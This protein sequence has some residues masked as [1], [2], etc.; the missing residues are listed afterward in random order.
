[1]TPVPVA[2]SE[3]QVNEVARQAGANPISLPREKQ[4]VLAGGE[5]SPTGVTEL[6]LT[7][8]ADPSKDTPSWYTK[9]SDVDALFDVADTLDWLADSGDLNENYDYVDIDTTATTPA[10]VYTA[11]AMT[12]HGGPAPGAGVAYPSTTSMNTLPRIESGAQVVV[13]PLPS[14]F[15]GAPT[16]DSAGV[17]DMDSAEP[18]R[19]L[20]LHNL[21][22]TSVTDLDN[23]DRLQVFGTHDEE[24]E[25]VS[26][27]LDHDDTTGD[28]STSLSALGVA[29]T[30]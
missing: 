6:S 16:D 9:G 30:M 2:R 14:L 19:K 8:W 17:P 25:F 12:P 7:S 23:D 20:V 15:D 13:P 3:P 4:T 21:N 1:M 18:S 26:T 27:I 29:A 28:S 10:P 5:I 11:P 24:E 22:S